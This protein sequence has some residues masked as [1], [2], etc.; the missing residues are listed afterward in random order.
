[1]LGP[2]QNGRRVHGDEWTCQLQELRTDSL[3]HLVQAHG[4]L[5][6]G[7]LSKPDALF[8]SAT[9][10]FVPANIV[11]RLCSSLSA[12]PLVAPLPIS[13]YLTPTFRLWT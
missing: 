11:H 13:K 2:G 6:C 10:L 8:V 5:L 12:G 7:C 4:H 9:W 3:A 1:M